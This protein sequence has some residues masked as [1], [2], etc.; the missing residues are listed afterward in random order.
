MA[1]ATVVVTDSNFPDL[2]IERRELA[3]VAD[4]VRAD[5]TTPE[6]VAEAAA[7]A[8]A[9]ALLVQY[10][11]I[12]DAVFREIDDLRVIG[13]YGIGVDNVDV[14]S[15][16]EFGVTVVNVPSYCEDEVAEHALALLLACERR[17]VQYDAAV[18]DGRW[19]WKLGRPIH[20][21]RGLTLGLAGF[22][23]IPRRLVEKTAG[24]GFEYVAYDPYVDAES[25][26]ELGVEK[27]DFEGLVAGADAISIHV[28]LTDE[29]EG[30]FDADAFAAMDDAVVV[31]T[32]RGGIVDEDAL[33]EA[34]TSGA[35]RAA[36]LDV[37]SEEPP[38]DSPLL[39]RDEVVLT[40][41]VA[42]YSEDS[43]AELRRTVA[44]DVARVLRGENPDNPVN[45]LDTG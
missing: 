4:V 39:D 23:K 32:S 7:D 30:L 22:G 14:E 18:K 27:V 41:H 29:T 12:T 31:N 43:V 35:V 34:L 45:D 40:P 26:A 17:V 2:S 3:T 1:D 21:L 15:A 42:W 36:G 28:P 11:E 16:T 13:R 19:D 37:L 33:G 44:R 9:D 20:R 10:A 5:A 25:M 24:L 8:D 6:E 38:E